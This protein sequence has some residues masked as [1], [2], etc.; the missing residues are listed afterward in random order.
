MQKDLRN[1]IATQEA[2]QQAKRMYISIGSKQLAS[3][4]AEF[5]NISYQTVYD[6]LHYRNHSPRAMKIRQRA[7]ELLQ[8]EADAVVIELLG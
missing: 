5:S 8:A 7:K 4:R 3:L 6:S 1:D 2:P